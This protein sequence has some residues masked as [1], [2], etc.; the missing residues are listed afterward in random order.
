M[1]DGILLAAARHNGWAN[2]E[3]IRFCAGLSPE[4]LAWTV[5]GTYGSIHATL[6]H[7]VAAEHG[8]LLALTGEAPPGGPL[9]PGAG[10]VPLDDLLARARSNAARV[11]RHFASETD[12][13]RRITRPSGTVATAAVI[14]AQ[15][16][17]HGSDHRAHVGTILGAQGVEPP[18]LDVWS[19]GMGQGL[20]T[21]P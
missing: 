20:V 19:Y 6:Q 14:A 3:L 2:A 18:D 12:P 16:I 1:S 5:P 7:I 8:Y 17:H 10:L 4:Q 13:D 9:P 15:F 11:E 21:R